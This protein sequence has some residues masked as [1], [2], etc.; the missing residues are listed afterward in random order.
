M[1]RKSGKCLFEF[2]FV[3]L[4]NIKGLNIVL[5]KIGAALKPTLIIS[6]NEDKWL[7]K[8]ISTFKNEIDEFILGV[9][10]HRGKR[11]EIS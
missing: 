9:E 10:S 2:N 8:T 4:F 11:S 3:V 6:I 5:R 1:V 7:I